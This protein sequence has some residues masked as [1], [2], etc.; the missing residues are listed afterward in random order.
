MLRRT[1]AL[2][3]GVT[4]A[5]SV[6]GCQAQETT[7]ESATV[8]LPSAPAPGHDSPR[9]AVAGF[10]Q[11]L[12]G[13]DPFKACEYLDPD[14]QGNCLSGFDGTQVVSGGWSVGDQLV[15]HHSALV[16]G[17]F[18]HFCIADQCQTN[19]DPRAGLDTAAADFEGSY[20]RA[21]EPAKSPV[22]ACVLS[23]G[24]WYVEG[25]VGLSPIP[26]S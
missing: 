10:L 12:S 6:A 19:T 15:R 26:A 16:V 25:G 9:A 11:G 4:L 3:S 14:Q 22:V 1:G 23:G 24:K 21:Q 7:K 8:S 18:A 20:E 13:G 2:V 17:L 5:L